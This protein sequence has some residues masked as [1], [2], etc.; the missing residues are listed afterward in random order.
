MPELA[1]IKIMAE[2]I[3]DVCHDKDFTTISVSSEVQ[4]RLS[5]VQPIDLQVFKVS[6]RSRGKELLLIFDE[7]LLGEKRLS[8]TMGMSGHW[9]F[10]KSFGDSNPTPKHSHLMINTYQ[11]EEKLCLV[12]ARRFA[13]WKWV[14]DFS[15]NRGPCPV[16]ETD[17]FKKHVI[18][19][20]HRKA[21]DK[22]IHL[23]LMDQRY[24]NGIGNYLRAEI[25]Y[26]AEQDPFESAREAILS[27]PQI[28]ELCTQVPIEA[29]YLGGGSLKD[30]KNPFD[31]LTLINFSDWLQ[32]YGKKQKIKDASGRMLW[33]D[34]KFVSD[35]N[36]KN[37]NQI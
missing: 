13:K 3:N 27:N 1:E 16:E 36:L 30:W 25:L 11:G 14:D 17:S 19:N 33:F 9:Y 7:G 2:Y 8:V 10:H 35:H 23:V 29:Y 5:L 15:N 34:P 20:L 24:F 26:L 22:P 21:F 31:H 12:D 28:L 37:I 6:A 4:Q 32:C 18:D